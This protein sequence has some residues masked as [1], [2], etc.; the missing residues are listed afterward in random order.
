MKFNSHSMTLQRWVLLFD[1]G[2]NCFSKLMFP[3]LQF[4]SSYFSYFYSS[5][6]LM[7]VGSPSNLELSFNSRLWQSLHRGIY[8][9]APPMSVLQF[10]SAVR[11]VKEALS[12]QSLQI[13]ESLITDSHLGISSLILPQACLK[14]VPC[15]E[16]ITTIFWLLAAFSANSTMSAK[17]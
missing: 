12:L 13:A 16:L 1:V 4:R 14:N 11:N 17:N 10:W 7:M 6:T 2:R 15:S 3:I 5:S 9:S 8:I